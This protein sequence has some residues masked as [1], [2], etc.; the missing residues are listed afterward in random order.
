MLLATLPSLAALT[1]QWLC[2]TG[3]RIGDIK[4]ESNDGRIVATN[5]TGTMTHS[6]AVNSDVPNAYFNVSV[7][8]GQEVKKWI[9]YNVD[10]RHG[11]PSQTNQF[12]GAVTE[13]VWGYNAADTS[14]KNIV[15]DFDYITYTLEYNG[16]G[17][18][19]SMPS[20]SHVY[21][22]NFKLAANQFSKTGYSFDG[23]TSNTGAV[24]GNMDSVSG[25][26][27]GVTYTNTTTKTATLYV[28]WKRNT[29]TVTFDPC[30]GSVTSGS[31]SVEYDAAWPALPT[32]TR[33]GYYFDGWYNDDHYNTATPTNSTVAIT[34]NVTIYAKWTQRLTATF[35][36]P[37]GS[38]TQLVY[39]AYGST[40][41]APYP[42]YHSG[43]T[44]K[45]WS[46]ELG[47]IT[48]DTIYT[49]Q[50]TGTQYFIT[51]HSNFG[52]PEAT[53]KIDY[54][55]GTAKAA[56][57]GATEFPRAGYSFDGWATSADSNQIRFHAGDDIVT[58]SAEGGALYA[59]WKPIK[60]SISF[61]ANGGNGEMVDVSVEYDEPYTVTNCTFTKTGVDFVGWTTN[62]DNGAEFYPDDSVSNLTTTAD[63]TVT[64]YAVWSE[65][66]YIAF[67][68]NGADNPNSMNDD[69]MTFEGVETKAL[70]PNEFEKTGYTFVGWATNAT[71]AAALDVAYTNREEVVSTNLWMEIGE[72]NDFY[73][74][75]QTNKYTI[76][77]NPNGGTGLMDNQPFVYDQAQALTKCTIIS[78]LGFSGWATN[79]TGD[80]VFNDCADVSNL[81]AVADGAIMLYAKW[82]NG[83][84]SKAMH[85]DNL[86]WDSKNAD[87]GPDWEID[88]SVGYNQSGSSVYSKVEYPKDESKRLV[89]SIATEQAG[90]LS[91]RYKT[92]INDSCSLD[93]FYSGNPLTNLSA[94]VKWSDPISISVDNIANVAIRF[95]RGNV[96]E[97]TVWIDQMKWEPAGGGLEPSVLTNAVPSAVKGLVYDGMAKTGVPAGVGYTISGNVATNAWDDYVATATPNDYCVWPDGSSG[98][99]NIYWSIAKATN[100]MSGVTFT[101]ATFVVDGEAHSIYVSGDLP[102]GVEVSYSGNGKIEPGEYEVT[103][104]FTVDT[105][106][107]VPI[108]NM[109][110]T[111]TIEKRTIPVPIAVAGL[112]YNGAEQIGVTNGVGYTI[113][114]NV[115]TNA[116]DD[117]VATA[118]PDIYCAWPDGSFGPTNIHWS[119]AKAIYD[120]SGV[121]FT[122][123]TYAADGEAHSIY[124]SGDL[125]DGVMVSYFGN[126]KTEPGEYE[127]TATFTGDAENYEPIADWT[128]QLT[129]V[130][131]PDP[132]PGSDDPPAPG[133]DEPT[134]VTTDLVLHPDGEPA[135][136]AFTA[137][138]AETYVGWL[139]DGSGSI[140]AQLTVKTSAAKSGKASKSTITVTPVGGKKYTLKTTVQPGGNPMDEFGITYGAL[141]LAGTLKGFAVEASADVAKSKDASVKAL[142]GKIPVGTYTF[143]VKTGDG[144]A[145]FSATVDK[146]GKTRVQGFLGNGTKV[147][148]SATGSI[149]DTY[150]AVPVVVSKS[151]VSFG[152]VL[153]IP[154][155][156]GSPVFVGAIGS[157]WQALRAGGAIAMSNGIHAFDF[158]APTFRSYIAAV[159]ST[160]V[161]P[162]GEA[163]TVSGSKWVFAKTSGK[164]K[165]VDGV[166]SVVA[167]GEP[168]NLSGLKLTHTAKTGLVKG[169]FKLYYM[170]GG[171]IKSDKV[172]I[173]GVV[174][175]G[176][177]MGNGTV[178]KL[179]SFA[180]WAE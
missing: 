78:T 97:A 22:N 29:Y 96:T 171:K 9:A 49:A 135:L 8:A 19:G 166:L 165:V 103:A 139:R 121:M 69:I 36:D 6:I 23:W 15:V 85:C 43:Y 32:P 125:P 144:T 88:Q 21:T 128:V 140:V 48:Q 109:T 126:D 47:N 105:D 27:F 64:F 92:S 137:E 179:G 176:I 147:S 170:D 172:T 153:W 155:A 143:V 122:N 101:G 35:I 159:G 80:V 110:A 154:L 28:K 18:S 156:G 24:F 55:Y 7:P 73:A 76:V 86:F 67:N 68:G 162:V 149:G 174:S 160:P 104:S 132:D 142:A 3:Y 60:Y 31:V 71:T 12:A 169:S 10:P 90:T 89:P 100:D 14:T 77:F 66:R 58:F 37:I 84:L 157:S 163:F 173:V 106:N 115:A 50:F 74:V 127:V 72:T 118:T 111:M 16:N 39:V 42:P 26:S 53:R 34:E 61:N 102:D 25:A 95:T 82:N 83:V 112:V 146:K 119:I 54:V 131:N 62:V 13:Y 178:K 116:W 136:N 63:A 52:N 124:V 20:K 1:N 150:F 123:E 145:V 120:M 91:F 75:W 180:V 2:I 41:T 94:N 167:N 152:F 99:T 164:L 70:V 81:T 168:S 56:L 5:S 148:V 59:V 87:S 46:P 57:D 151:K 38:T 30:G 130:K 141:G 93:V 11:I 44:F 158:E 114:G 161:A 134:P 79:S 40:P 133:P 45:E 17:G 129:I 177:F 4:I 138:K 175:E 51:Y 33:D 98:P 65:P 117:Y 107:Y 113:S 108:D